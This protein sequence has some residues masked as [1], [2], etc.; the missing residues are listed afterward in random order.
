VDIPRSTALLVG[1][2]NAGGETARLCKALGMMTLGVDARRTEA[3]R[4][5]GHDGLAVGGAV[6]STH[7]L[8][9]LFWRF[10]KSTQEIHRVVSHMIVAMG[11]RVILTRPCVFH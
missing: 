7:P 3:R 10:T 5:L 8:C 2:G 6:I 11:G 1:V 4:G 9:I